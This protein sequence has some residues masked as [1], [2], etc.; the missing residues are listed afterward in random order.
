MPLAGPPPLHPPLRPVVVRRTYRDA[1]VFA[2][3][4]R[5]SVRLG[6]TAGQRI[7]APCTGG[8]RF[9]GRVAGGSPV[10]T[11]GCGA[12]GLRVTV[13]GITPALPRGAPVRAGG[14]LGT[15]LGSELGL[16]VRRDGIGYVDP[17]P[18]LAREAGP[19]TPTV[20]D[21]PRRI[22]RPWRAA[23]A[24]HGLRT[25]GTSLVEASARASPTADRSL[26]LTGSVLGA[27]GLLI[28]A[29]RAIA[30]RRGGRRTT[31]ARRAA[32]RR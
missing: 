32:L 5:R 15:A 4:A 3:G 31:A 19:S 30:V 10:I 13:G 1:P 24:V 23:P 16:S 22:Q 14:R 26:G 28:W 6:A 21:V 27:T 8:V 17:V 7:A 12:W 20:L 25:V 2:A 9:A 11:V 29:A 18:L